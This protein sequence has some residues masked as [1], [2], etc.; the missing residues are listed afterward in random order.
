MSSHLP[1]T[2]DDRDIQSFDLNSEGLPARRTIPD[3][4]ATGEPMPSSEKAENPKITRVSANVSG[5]EYSHTFQNGVKKIFFKSVKMTRVQYGWNSGESGTKFI[6]IVQGGNYEE[7]GLW[8]N[9]RTLYFQTSSNN[10]TL[11]IEEWT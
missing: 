4:N 11:E 2:L 8:L 3:F 9:G 1:K 5:D 6:T 7:S 10:N